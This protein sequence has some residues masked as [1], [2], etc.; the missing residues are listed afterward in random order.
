MQIN[1]E[2]KNYWSKVGTLPDLLPTS[3]PLPVSLNTAKYMDDATIQEAVDLTK[4]LATKLDCFGPL[5]WWESSG[6]LLPDKNTLLNSEIE[7][8]KTISDEREMVLNAS[9]TKLL[10]VNFTDS[11]QFQSLLTI[12]GSSS[13]IELT[14][15]TK[16]LRYWLTSSMKPSKHVAHILKIAYGRLWAISRLKSANVNNEDILHFFNV[17]IRSVLEFAAPVFSSMLTK[18][19][20]VDIE[21]IQ[22]IALKVI[23]NESYSSYDLA[24]SDLKTLSLESRRSDLSLSFALKC[25]KSKSHS[26]FFKQRTSTYYQLRKIKAFE[27]P[28]CHSER[29][30]SSPIPYLTRL[31]NEYYSKKV[32]SY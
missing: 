7:T 26:H 6:K 23:L 25:T 15:E 19:N 4:N 9:K 29:Y 20:I 16:L 12:P 13:P 27:E 31:L 30:K 10:I 14:F 28:L 11:H 2:I 3:N 18:E 8:V 24:C 21:R 17:K 5:P 1:N 32:G 22:K